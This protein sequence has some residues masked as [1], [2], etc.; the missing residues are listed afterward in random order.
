MASP[1]MRLA[2]LA[3]KTAVVT[4]S[5][6]GIGKAVSSALLAQGCSVLGLDVG[7]APTFKFNP[8]PLATATYT[9]S[10]CDL[11]DS[12]A[13]S[14]AVASSSPL[15]FVV[16]VAGIDPKFSLA[17]GGE[18]AW[19]SIVDLNLR[20]YYML[21]RAALPR[22]EQG[23]GKAVVNVSSINYKL[24]VPRRTLYT[25]SK[26]GVLGLTRGLSRE[27]GAKGIRINTVSPGWVW[28]ETQREAFLD[29]PSDG[30]KY[31]SYLREVQS[32]PDTRIEGEDIANHVLFFLSGASRACTG[33]NLVVDAGWT[34][35]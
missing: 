10:R 13:V 27:L 26:N 30:E 8:P 9:H 31:R 17:E 11:R 15:D 4:G 12:A 1:V 2:D 5:S 16:N 22:L 19:H 33:S 21:I 35:E 18:E 6:M 20:G 14:S 32:L 34:L 28:T 25:I 3:G 29:H 24:G 7:P 23:S